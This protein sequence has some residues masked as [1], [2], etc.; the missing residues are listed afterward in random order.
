M[1]TGRVYNCAP[2]CDFS[3]DRCKEHLLAHIRAGIS[4]R[5]HS[6]EIA[7][8]PTRDD[9]LD[10]V[11]LATMRNLIKNGKPIIFMPNVVKEQLRYEKDGACT[12]IYMIGI[13][14]CGSKTCVELAGFEIYIDVLIP[15]DMEDD[16]FKVELRDALVKIME[17]G[18]CVFRPRVVELFKMRGFQTA[19]SRY[20]RFT[21]SSLP[22]RR[23]FLDALQQ[24]K[25][26]TMPELET[27]SDD[28]G[29]YFLKV[30]RDFKFATADWNRIAKYTLVTQTAI[31]C[32]YHLLV[33]VR[34]IVQLDD[35]QRAK[36]AKLTNSFLPRVIDKDPLVTMMWDIETYSTEPGVPNEKSAFDLFMIGNAFFFHH[37]AVPLFTACVVDSPCETRPGI[38]VI[39]ECSG[40]VG[41]L[42]SQIALLEKMQPDV[43][44]TFNGANFDWPMFCAK[45]KYHNLLVDLRNA[46]DVLPQFNM[47]QEKVQSF[48]FKQGRS[49]ITMKINADTQHEMKMVGD[50]AGVLDI[51]VM[52]IFMRMYPRAEIR[53]SRSLNFFL[54]KNGLE[55][56]EDMPYKTMFGIYERA[57][58]FKR[59]KIRDETNMREM[60]DVAYYCIV[61]CIRPQELCV[62]RN[63]ISEFRELATLSYVS[64][65]DA[66]YKADGMKV[67]NVI[68]AYC[69]DYDIAFSNP[70]IKHSKIRNFYPG[71]WVFPPNRGLHSDRMGEL[72]NMSTL[73]PGPTTGASSPPKVRQ[74][75]ISGLDFASLYPS[76]MMAY[77]L[78]NDM[79]VRD[80]DEAERLRAA[81]YTLYEIG[82]FE[83]R[84]GEKKNDS[85][86][87]VATAYGWVVHHNGIH[88]FESRQTI[89]GYK[90]VG[91][92]KYEPIAG[93]E[94]LPG[95]RMGILPFV[96]KKIYDKRVPI[97][98]EFVRLSKRK[99]ELELEGRAQTEEYNDVLFLLNKAN[100]KQ[101]A[102]KILANTFYG[103]CGD[104]LSP[105]YDTLVAGGITTRGQENIKKV[106]KYVQSLGC[107]IH[108]GDTDSLYLSLNDDLFAKCDAEYFA[109][110]DAIFARYPGVH[111]VLEWDP[112]VA[113]DADERY[114][115]DEIAL[116]REL[117]DARIAWWTAQVE[118][119][120]N[121]MEN[122]RE[123]VLDF[124]VADNKTLFLKMAYEE[125]GHPTVMCGKK[126]YFMTPHISRV[127]FYPKEYMVKGLEFIKQGQTK[128]AKI[129]STE[130]IR[131][132]LAPENERDLIDITEDVLRRFFT[133]KTDPQLFKLTAR[134]NPQRDNKSVNVFV[135]RMR[136][137]YNST[138]DPELKLLYEPPDSGD[139]FEYV[140]VKRPQQ[141]TLSGNIIHENKSAQ[142]EF[143]DVFTKMHDKLGMEIDRNHYMTGALLGIFARF[144]AYHP[145]F[146]PTDISIEDYKA[147]DKASVDSARRYLTKLINEYSGNL[148]LARSQTAERYKREYREIR[149]MLDEELYSLPF[150]KTCSG[151]KSLDKM[152]KIL[153]SPSSVI[154]MANAHVDTVIAAWPELD[155]S[156]K[157]VD[158]ELLQKLNDVY[159]GQLHTKRMA[160]LKEKEI[161]ACEELTATISRLAE[162]WGE[163]EKAIEAAVM[164]KRA[165][166][167]PQPFHSNLSDVI[168]ELE[169]KYDVVTNIAIDKARCRNIFAAIKRERVRRENL[170][171][172]ERNSAK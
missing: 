104:P 169:D 36:Y 86:N 162:I 71:A 92:S 139:K 152:I 53:K 70:P 48:S 157:N 150:F 35:E 126:K 151:T 10:R 90:K 171:F 127:N 5:I 121:E 154:E 81:G 110:R 122:L 146:R 7:L 62:K 153:L 20:L 147:Y 77:N 27:A 138:S 166:Q 69:H 170:K 145:K 167:E 82:P 103:K 60:A 33:D 136:E 64:M 120:M 158:D 25:E 4:T 56:K 124:L 14:P 97:K 59:Q 93:R 160:W 68:A 133:M 1:S 28:A 109:R 113:P 57:K 132:V 102:L 66:V 95:E 140:V 98:D 114:S 100:A 39:I 51:D 75:P 21:F 80:A 9:F 40:Q 11:A 123:K 96:V 24:L 31:N 87:K 105:I 58:E 129:L 3:D 67:I 46:L 119:T 89:A 79:I 91:P 116:K 85:K 101:K 22:E 41:V 49:R 125:V 26:T 161:T 43:M 94:A 78:S 118:I 12:K 115:A 23:A 155:E 2:D 144:I 143:F 168:Y 38:S 15:Q 72:E 159:C 37:S 54:E 165:G 134:Y 76:L 17:P 84:I 149:L 128:I 163:R 172:R 142:M 47:D 135:E 111:H 137:L 55:S 8:L 45:L 83:Y 148:K 32:K 73:S 141:Y 18:K 61:D 88:D 156:Y 99:E 107:H 42:K 16:K 112:L 50:F 29:A 108:Y 44:G 130:I 19:K 131:E 65:F 117:I 164:R 52:P 6:K 63:I 34:D 74:R 30:A 106:A 13:L